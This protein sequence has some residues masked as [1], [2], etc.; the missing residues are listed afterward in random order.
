MTRTSLLLGGLVVALMTT[1]GLPAFAEE[2][3]AERLLNAGSADEAGNWLMVHRNYESTRFSPLNEITTDNVS[4]LK[5]AYAVPLGGGEPTGFGVGSIQST[6]LAKDGFL[7]LTDPWGTPYKI[8]ASSG[9]HGDIVWTCDTGIDKD[10]TYG[11]SATNRG[12]ALWNNLVIGVLIDGRVIACDDETGEVAWEN[13]VAT[14]TGEGFSNAPLAIGDKILVGQSFGDFG[15]RGWVAGLDAAT[16]EEVWRFNTVPEPGA[17][18]SETWK[19]EEAGNPDCWKTGGA[20]AWVTGSYDPDTGLSYWGTGNPTPMFDPEYRP[21]DNLYSNSVI[22]LDPNTGELK[23]HFQFTPG[24]YMDY[25]EVGVHMV[26]NTEIDGAARKILAHFGRN[27]FFYTLDRTNGAFI[28]AKPYVAKV[29]WTEGIDPKTGLPIGY[30]PDSS[31]QEYMVGQAPRRDG[32]KRENCPNIQG[33]V[34]F[35]PPA[36]NPELNMAYGAGIQGCSNVSTEGNDP[37]KVVVG[38]VFLGGNYEDSGA[39]TGAIW[40]MNV[41]EG[42]ESAR[43][44]R[45]YPNYSGVMATPSLVFSG[46][47]DGTFA[48]FDAK[49]L[50]QKWSI[51]LGVGFKAP[52]MTFSVNGKQFIAIAGGNTGGSTFGHAELADRNHAE[53][54]FVFAL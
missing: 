24:D 29:T 49:T 4:G 1:S 18:G 34:N 30:N 46:E 37:A 15:T 16:G 38:E 10:P 52:P 54:L 22:A 41:S 20:A 5:L 8:D 33:G 12:L 7:Y 51:N 44:D 36:Y 47:L 19:C 45:P 53:M 39:Q 21:G 32:E 27:G 42:T 25:D 11:Q 50:E 43:A 48:A 13:Q 14:E 23:W 26:V 40:G 17:P 35:W 28:G 9:T 31:L 3:T 6:P 2:A